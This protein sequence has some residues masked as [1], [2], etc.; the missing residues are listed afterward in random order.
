MQKRRG[1]LLQKLMAVL[2]SAVLVTGMAL[3]AEAETVSGNDA[4]AET[5]AESTNIA[6]GTDWTLGADGR[7]TIR[8]D[9]GMNNWQS[10]RGRYKEAVLTV[11]IQ[12][13]VTRIIAAAFMDCSNLTEITIPESVTSIG[14]NAFH[15]CKKLAGI[16]IPGKVTSIEENAFFNCSS[17]KTA[18]LPDGLKSI[19][20]LAFGST[21]LEEIEIPDSVESIGGNAF[22]F[23]KSLKKAVL[24]AKLTTIEQYLFRE[25]VNLTE[26]TIPDNVTTIKQHAFDLCK[27][28]EEIK[29]PDKVTDIG[30]CAFSNCKSLTKVE[31]PDSVTSIGRDAFSGCSSLTE[32][33][34]PDK[35]TGIEG[36]TFSGC[37]GLEKITLPDNVT[38]IGFGAFRNCS[39][40]TEITVPEGV[41]SIQE[42]VFSGCSSLTEITLPDNVTSIEF[43]AFENCSSLT[44]ITL[45]DK[46]THIE[47][48]AF[49]NCSSLKRIIMLAEE[50]PQYKPI[51]FGA[52]PGQ[53]AE[54]KG[55]CTGCP[56]IA[57]GEKG[58]FVPV[59]TEDAYKSADGW[60]IYEENIAEILSHT[61][62]YAAEWKSNETSHWRECQCGDKSGE[63]DHDFGDWITDKEATAGEAGTK[64]REC[65]TCAYRET[66]TIPATGTEPGTGTVTPEVKP[67]TGTITPEVKPDTGTV[68]PEVRPGADAPATDIS[69]PAGELE[70][71]LLTDEEKQLV[72]SGTDIRIVL[73]VQDA[74]SSV[75]DSDKNGIQQA[76]NGFT[77]GQYLNI[78]LYKLI[79]EKRTDINETAK[80]IKIVITIP[81]SLKNTD[82]NRAKT[83]AVIRVHAGGAEL[84]SDL[85]NSADTITIETDR[86]STYAIVYKDS[87]SENSGSSQDNAGKNDTK[88]DSSKDDE[89]ETG[90]SVPLELCATLAMI[91]GFAY[92]F[93][94]FTDRKRGMTEETKKALVSRLVRWA[95]LGGK[96]RKCLALAAVFVLLVYYHSIGK[97][98]CVEWEN[99]YG[100]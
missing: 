42:A 75:S 39:S 95:K 70:D 36:Q 64:H 92:L 100:E 35:V 17:L 12:S 41:T 74:G 60:K 4:E 15:S 26:I 93:L 11:E 33:V 22:D 46:V 28:L 2:L 78:D 25:C 54:D 49:E 80:K 40:L 68:T 69:T 96:L 61:H 91:A 81:D 27:S 19:G 59:G 56:F 32:I 10:N 38:S 34:I 47:T 65:R 48:S 37:S 24:S 97:K 76:L 94:Y 85:D 73:E 99:A 44:E 84:L 63:A 18:V 14:M 52:W 8:S 88:P 58:I 71:M 16:T 43:E 57:S 31:I 29:I 53:E 72:Q 23:C 62:S 83:F 82:S 1:S 90:D 55:F 67:D 50:P 5:V 89:P 30:A 79:G 7:L 51:A 9:E 87:V 77:V 66:E 98:T 3:N 86:F 6:S 13:G 21:I 45:P 20:N